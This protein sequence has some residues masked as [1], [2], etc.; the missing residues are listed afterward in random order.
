MGEQ[1]RLIG[2]GRPIER[3]TM[4][5]HGDEILVDDGYAL[6]AVEFQ[7]RRG[8]GVEAWHPNLL[9]LLGPEAPPDQNEVKGIGT[10]RVNGVRPEERT[11]NGAHENKA[12][13]VAEGRP[14]D[15]LVEDGCGAG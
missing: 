1:R 15:P 3:N 2:R 10:R 4:R 6:M 7:V 11:L 8:I 12:L 13:P 5:M 9:S 14:G